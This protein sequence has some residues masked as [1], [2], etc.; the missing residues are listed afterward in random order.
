M[1]VSP[2]FAPVCQVRATAGA[3]PRSNEQRWDNKR[4]SEPVRRSRA[5]SRPGDV[6]LRARKSHCRLRPANCAAR[7]GC[8]LVSW[9]ATDAAS[10][11]PPRVP[12]VTAAS[13][14]GGWLVDLQRSRL[15]RDLEWRRAEGRNKRK[16]RVGHQRKRERD[17]GTHTNKKKM[18]NANTLVQAPLV[19][20]SS[21]K[22]TAR[23]KSG[24]VSGKKDEIETDSEAHVVP[25]AYAR[26]S[27]PGASG[28]LS[29]APC[30][31]C[32]LF[33]P[34][35]SLV[36]GGPCSHGAACAQSIARSGELSDLSGDERDRRGAR[37][38]A[39]ARVPDAVRRDH[40]H[41]SDH[42]ADRRTPLPSSI[43]NS[44]PPTAPPRHASPNDALALALGPGFGPAQ[45]ERRV[46]VR[47]PQWSIQFEFAFGRRWS[48]RR[49]RPDDQ[50][51]RCQKGKRRRGRKRN[52]TEAT[53]GERVSAR[54]ERE[55][56]AT[57]H[58]ASIASPVLWC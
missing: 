55:R 53:E 21:A 14:G 43:V 5:S 34:R 9:C 36:F 52:P 12:S 6:N 49:R 10:A 28:C 8:A 46:P 38:R 24:R 16:P 13:G 27:R 54:D 4:R 7:G 33:R 56:A 51:S 44:S 41:Q 17:E 45:R 18:D 22:S 3:S 29:C 47:R 32:V 31:L 19:F 26:T 23:G 15:A 35:L 20:A 25:T 39:E 11:P 50:H 58:A 57:V 48:T 40:D 30:V 37:G 42:Q 2:H 1:D